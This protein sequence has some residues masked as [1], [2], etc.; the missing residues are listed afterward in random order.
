MPLSASPI[1]PDQNERAPAAA[2][3]KAVTASVAAPPDSPAYSAFSKNQIILI[4]CLASF[5]ASF[6]P[7]SSFIFFPAIDDLAQALDVSV[8]KVNL[9]ITSYM[10]VAGLAP[11]ILGDLADN[12][13]RR[14]IY[15]FMMIVYCIANTGLALQT[16]WTAL[17]LL[18][19][20]QSTGSAATIALGYGVVSDVAPPSERGAFVSGLVIGPN[21]ATAIGPILGGALTS[22]AGW[23]W[24]FGFLA[25]WSSICVLLIALLLPETARSVV[26]NGSRKVSTLRRPLIAIS[27]FRSPEQVPYSSGKDDGSGTAPVSRPEDGRESHPFKFPNP[28]ASLKLLWAKDSALITLIFGVFYMNLSSLQATTSTLFVEIHSISGIGLGLVYLPSGIGSCIGAYYAGNLMDH[29]YR[30]VARKHNFEINK[31]AGDDLADFPIEKA[32]FRSIWYVLSAAG[33]SMVGYGWSMHFRVH[34]AVPLVLHF[35]IGLSIAVVFN[36]SGTLLV[37]IHPKSPSTAQAANSLV[38]AFL[39]GAGTAC[40]QPCIDAVGVGWTFTLFGG[41]GMAFKYRK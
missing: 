10:I 1:S 14:M 13:G 23:R 32:R 41:L 12:I 27:S 17:F 4:L 19:M 3:E 5:A 30:V 28:L 35:V 38:R 6:S 15:L 31:R 33:L 36:M 26:G 11:A 22:Y 29:D 34:M 9:T 16:N 21:I 2:A 20:L 37:D 7:L 18:R 40:V 25:I 8:G 39:A 24:I